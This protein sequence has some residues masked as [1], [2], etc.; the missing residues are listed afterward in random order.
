MLHD[1]VLMLAPATYLGALTIAILV[2]LLRSYLPA[3]R[4]AIAVP[5]IIIMVPGVYAFQAIAWFNRGEMLDALQAAHRAASFLARS[6]WGW[7]PCSSLIEHLRRGG[8]G[9][10]G[11]EHGAPDA[12]PARCTFGFKPFVKPTIPRPIAEAMD[13]VCQ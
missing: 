2:S 4:L 13:F 7:R 6:R 1:S 10:R 8:L 11:Q 9:F 12:P 5:A 3:P